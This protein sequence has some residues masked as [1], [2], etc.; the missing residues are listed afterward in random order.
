MNIIRLQANHNMDETYAIIGFDN[1][2]SWGEV[3]YL[4][5]EFWYLANSSKAEG[6]GVD[7]FNRIMRKIPGI[8]VFDT[9]NSKSIYV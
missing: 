6:T 7:K 8:T 1:R 3:E 5:K 2:F 9:A 4:M